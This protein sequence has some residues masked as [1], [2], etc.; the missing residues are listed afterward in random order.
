MDNKH[1]EKFGFLNLKAGFEFGSVIIEP[2]PHFEDANDYMVDNCH[3]DGFFYPPITHS[4]EGHYDTSK[5]K[6]VYGDEIPNTRRASQYYMIPASH[7]ISIKNPVATDLKMGDA[8]LLVHLLAFLYGTRVQFAE[9]SIDG[10][11]PRNIQGDIASEAVGF[12]NKANF[13][14]SFTYNK[15]KGWSKECQLLYINILYMHSR[16]LSIETDWESFVSQYMVFD[17]LYKLHESLGR[18]IIKGHAAR[19]I[20]MRKYYNLAEHSEPALSKICNARNKLFHEA[21]WMDSTPG[22]KSSNGEDFWLNRINAR[23]IVA[24]TGYDNDYVH[25][26]WWTFGQKVFD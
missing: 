5:K 25:F 8:G 20:G 12:Q 13:F 17:A 16:S 3:R 23:L 7:Q 18:D 24:I 19:L 2:L 10:R 15:W 1:V 4:V 9:W 11:I 26:P 21:L 22:H 14:L 6:I